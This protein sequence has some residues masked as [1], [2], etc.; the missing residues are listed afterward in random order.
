MP[1]LKTIL[2]KPKAMGLATVYFGTGTQLKWAVI[3]DIRS[4]EALLPNFMQWFI[5]RGRASPAEKTLN[6]ETV[7]WSPSTD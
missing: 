6:T 4:K 5:A 2:A 7:S 3:K 1:W